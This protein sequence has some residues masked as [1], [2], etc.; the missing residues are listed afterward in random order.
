MSAQVLLPL[1][2]SFSWISEQEGVRVL[3]ALDNVGKERL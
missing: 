3:V 1:L 2:A